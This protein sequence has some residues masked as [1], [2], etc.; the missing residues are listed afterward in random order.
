MNDPHERLVSARTILALAVP[1]LGALVAEPLFVL[2]DSAFVAHV[3]VQALGGLA[4]ASTIVTTVVGLSIFLAYSTTAAVARAVGE[5]D[6]RRA[7]SLGIDATYLG[8]SIGMVSALIVAVAAPQLVWLFGA[9]PEVAAEAVV[10]VRISAAGLP[11]MLL[12]QAALGV[13][14]GLQN[15]RITLVVAAVGAGA[16]IPVNWV[17]IFGLDMGIAG[18]ALGTVLCQWAMALWYGVIIVRGGREHQ[19][20]LTPNRGGVTS[21]WR[22]ARWLFVRTVSLRIVLIVSTAVAIHMGDAALAG[23]QLMNAV[24]ALSALA[25]D[26]LAIAAQALTGKFVGAGDTRSV[27]EV[28][29]VLIRWSLIGGVAVAL[30][31]LLASLVLPGVFTPDAEV[32]EQFRWALLVFVVAQPLAGYVFVLDGVLMGAGDFRYLAVAGIWTML[33]FIP[34]ALGLWWAAHTGVLAEDSPLALAYLW[35]VF[36]VVFLGSRAVSLGWRIRTDT[37][38]RA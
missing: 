19:V 31:L 4:V 24:F 26:S 33:A 15:T 17:L 7:L 32:Q 12:I 10:Y 22:E 23:H 13:V 25:L 2:V 11:A 29:R 27:H 35:A 5:G 1:A 18:S 37:W 38:M 34:G 16:N 30:V 20:A 36:T 14:R 8:A 3:A 28:M 9:G 21:A 6:L